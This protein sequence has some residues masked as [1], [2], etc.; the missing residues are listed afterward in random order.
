[1]LCKLVRGAGGEGGR[2]PRRASSPAKG[3]LRDVG[4]LGPS[5]CPRAPGRDRR[6]STSLQAGGTA[7]SPSPSDGFCLQV[8]AVLC[9]A[10]DRNESAA[11]AKPLHSPE[12]GAALPRGRLRPRVQIHPLKTWERGGVGGRRS[13]A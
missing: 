2:A 7:E 11:W 6:P 12:E 1:M 10:R 4:G 9:A 3:V 5:P 13:P 8:R